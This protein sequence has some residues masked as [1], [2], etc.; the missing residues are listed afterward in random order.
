VVAYYGQFETSG[1]EEAL[2][3]QSVTID[4]QDSSLAAV[5]GDSEKGE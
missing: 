5:P 1:A 2:E 3:Q 4:T